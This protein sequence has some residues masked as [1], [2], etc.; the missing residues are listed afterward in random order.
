MTRAEF[1]ALTKK[2]RKGP[3]T[4]WEHGLWVRYRERRL[5]PHPGYPSPLYDRVDP[6]EPEE[7]PYAPSFFRSMKRNALALGRSFAKTLEAEIRS[8]YLPKTPTLED[9]EKL[10]LRWGNDWGANDDET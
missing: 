8:K 6:R 9:L 4:Q 2:N 3:F 1:D 7:D 10:E 5:R